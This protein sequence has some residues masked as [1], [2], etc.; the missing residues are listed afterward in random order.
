[1]GSILP[2]SRHTG[3]DDPDSRPLP[4]RVPWETLSVDLIR[5]WGY[6]RGKWHPEHMEVLGPTGS[7]KSYFLKTILTMRAKIRGSHIVILATKP[8]DE[9]ISSLGWP[10]VTSWPPSQ[11]KKEN[12][13]VIYW[14]KAPTLDNDGLKKQREA[15]QNLLEKLWRPNSNIVLV[16]DEIA[17]IEQD[18]GL[19][20]IIRRYYREARALGIT[21][22]AG[23]QRPQ[24]VSRYMHSESEWTVCFKPKDDEDAERVA[25]ILG[26]K[27]YFSRVLMS[28]DRTKREFLLVHNLTGEAYI[29]H[30]PPSKA[31]RGKERETGQ[32]NGT[33]QSV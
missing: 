14:A 19:R 18:L 4:P 17:Y 13:Q 1:M 31:K 3:R 11:W 21:I 20:T 5:A 9:T 8:A 23:T 30:I 7:G 25:Q 29:S 22:V 15:V 10:V 28:L 32:R 27:R 33:D 12:A 26:N 24:G 6:P 16:L 2:T